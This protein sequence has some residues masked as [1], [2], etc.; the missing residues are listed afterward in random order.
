MKSEITVL[1]DN[2]IYNVLIAGNEKEIAEWA[3]SLHAAVKNQFEADGPVKILT[4]LTQT[5]FIDSFKIRGTISDMEKKNQPYVLKSAAFTPD[6]KI[7]W[8]SVIIAKM[9]GRRN[10]AIFKTKENALLWLQIPDKGNVLKETFYLVYNYLKKNKDLDEVDVLNYVR[11]ARNYS[12]D[13]GEINL[14]I[15]NIQQGTVYVTFNYLKENPNKDRDEA[16]N[17]IGDHYSELLN[18]YYLMEK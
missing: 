16:L 11:T 9:S 12:N 6:M 5:N 14:D 8:L 1:K 2:I 13:D 3:S 10:F 18:K 15:F 4:D 17:Y 7:R